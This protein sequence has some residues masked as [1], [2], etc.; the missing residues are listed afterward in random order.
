MR[1]KRN[2]ENLIFKNTVSKREFHKIIKFTAKSLL[3]IL[4]RHSGLK[5]DETLFIPDAVNTAKYSKD[6]ANTIASLLSDNVL[7][8]FVKKE[9]LSVG[10]RVEQR[11]GDGTTTAMIMACCFLLYIIKKERFSLKKKSYSELYKTFNEEFNR[12]QTDLPKITYSD[13]GSIPERNR[14]SEFAY[15]QA[16]SSTHGDT[17][18]SECIRE[19]FSDL[20][21]E[22]IYSFT[23]SHDTKKRNM[24][25]RFVVDENEAH[26]VYD[27]SCSDSAL[28]ND[29][30]DC[31]FKESVNALSFANSDFSEDTVEV[32]QLKEFVFD[33]IERTKKDV[34]IFCKSHDNR[35]IYKWNKEAKELYGGKGVYLFCPNSIDYSKIPPTEKDYLK[36]FIVEAI[37]SFGGKS[38]Y[39]KGNDYSLLESENVFKIKVKFKYGKLFIDYISDFENETDLFYNSESIKNHFADEKESF[40]FKLIEKVEERVKYLEDECLEDSVFFKNILK[41]KVFELK[42]LKRKVI[43]LCGSKRER[44]A[45]EDIV[46]DAISAAMSSVKNGA[47]PSP[48]LYLYLIAKREDILENLF[49]DIFISTYG[50]KPRELSFFRESDKYRYKKDSLFVSTSNEKTIIPFDMSR[51]RLGYKNA[52]YVMQP[53]N[54]VNST[55]N[56]ILDSILRFY[57]IGDVIC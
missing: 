19:I 7:Y 4:S 35:T 39:R 53:Y 23:Y 12:L 41:E 40:L 57:T 5:G 36:S 52:Y 8:A 49:R 55:F 6:G 29:E 16:M 42:Y 26:L 31:S 25:K 46:V 44:K 9:I 17:E 33:L 56:G 51:S 13:L 32:Y 50:F 54:T 45:N 37:A 18:L 48:I 47:C 34:F 21:E 30:F 15:M 3:K 11:E 10:K 2:R 38:P 1:K 28:I 24:D 20:K 43:L 22:D 14:I 27:M